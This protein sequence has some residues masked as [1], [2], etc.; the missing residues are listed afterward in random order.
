MRRDDKSP[1]T[2][3]RSERIFCM[4]GSWYFS[5]REG[6]LGP[7]TGRTGA[8]AALRTFL[9]EK[10]ELDAFQRSRSEPPRRIEKPVLELVAVEPAVK[11]A[12]KPVVKTGPRQPPP[13][14]ALIF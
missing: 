7:Y 2:Y 10:K 4:N 12:P 5:T 13:R 9:N 6:D 3:F 11:P 1:K 14:K 8:E